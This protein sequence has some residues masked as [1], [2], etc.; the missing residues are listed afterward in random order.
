MGHRW[1]VA[2]LVRSFL[3]VRLLIILLTLVCR[4][5]YPG[6][7]KWLARLL[8]RPKHFCVVRLGSERIGVS[9]VGTLLGVPVSVMTSVNRCTLTEILIVDNY[10]VDC[11]AW[12]RPDF[13]VHLVSE[14]QLLESVLRKRACMVVLH[15]LNRMEGLS[16]HLIASR[17]AH[18]ALRMV[19][20]VEAISGRLML[21]DAKVA[22]VEIVKHVVSETFIV[23][24]R[25]K[26]LS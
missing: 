1:V 11:P 23:L 21:V 26:L 12:R 5:L 20:R 8:A 18:V 7:R 17:V 9:H 22:V 3:I 10:L 4:L 24:Q 2:H 25:L 15:D 6:C 13:W 14:M 19:M 16:M